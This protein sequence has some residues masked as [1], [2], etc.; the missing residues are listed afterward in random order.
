MT[1]AVLDAVDSFV[2]F[3]A[4]LDQNAALADFR[5]G[6]IHSTECVEH[7]HLGKFDCVI[8][9]CFSLGVF[10]LPGIVMSAAVDRFE[11]A[12]FANVANPAA[13]A[14]RFHHSQI[15]MVV[16]EQVV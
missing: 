7:G 3:L 9:V 14:A 16:V 13:G 8:T 12:L 5:R 6:N 11:F 10:P 4:A 2:E 15:G 1:D